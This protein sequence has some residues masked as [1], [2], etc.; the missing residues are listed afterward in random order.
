MTALADLTVPAVHPGDPSY[1]S[2]RAVFN[3]MINRRPLVI[4]RC[5]DTADVAAGIRYAREH[6]LA[7]S[8]RSGGHGVAGNAVCD[9]G[10]MLDLSGMRDI[11]VDLDLRT[12]EAGPGLLLGDLD[13]A[14][15]RH[16]MA[17]PLGVMS[18]TGIAGLTLGGGLGWLNGAYGLAC[19][20]LVGARVVTADGE[21]RTVGP[22]AHPDLHWGLR[23]GGGNLGVVTSFRY[24]LHP[25]ARVL[26]GGLTFP[27][28]AARDA[29]HEHH[30][31]MDTA[32]DELS[33]AV[34]VGRDGVSVAVCWS[35]D[36]DR[37]EEVLRP[38]RLIAGGATD[39][40]V[41]PVD[42][43]DWQRAPDAAFPRGRCHYWKS[44]YLRHL[45]DAA[46]DDLLAVAATIPNPDT[47]IGLQGLRVR[48]HGCPS[49]P[50]RSRTAP[51]R[52]TSSS[53]ASGRTRPAPTRSSPGRATP[54]RRCARTSRTPSTSTTWAARATIASGRP[55]GPTTPASPSS[56]AA[57]TRR[58]SSDSTRTSARARNDRA[59]RVNGVGRRC[60][61]CCVSPGRPAGVMPPSG[62]HPR[63]TNACAGRGPRSSTNP[64]PDPLGVPPRCERRDARRRSV[65]ARRG[66][67]RV[68]VAP[69]LPRRSGRSATVDPEQ[70]RVT[71]MAGYGL[72]TVGTSA[73]RRLPCR[74]SSATALRPLASSDIDF[75]GEP[76]FTTL[77]AAPCA[78]AC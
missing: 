50:R 15:L 44:G 37:G 20:N 5:R 14:T 30:R 23:G 58:T 43:L 70:G 46:V 59:S 31:F 35:G 33:S 8:V 49:T 78:P 77:A 6:D 4:L 38:L 1:D 3:A 9:G 36:L 60:S 67:R 52:T 21:V 39:D 71:R 63:T 75:R 69:Q 74:D 16:E 17:T 64:R 42:F 40:T 28:P 18:G 47:S 19:D 72:R 66:A 56:N 11:A 25:V 51:P 76:A 12:A 10:V 57:T 22:D 68:H 48:P 13:R 41:G 53:W 27:G 62:P 55:S 32:P 24:R 26:A 29:L 7:L 45:T 65:G 73:T 2:D 54:S 61:R 34:S